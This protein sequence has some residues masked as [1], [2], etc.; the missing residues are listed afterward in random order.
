MTDW[1]VKMKRK[2]DK[3]QKIMEAALKVFAEKGFYLAS[4]D[5]IAEKSQISK[6]GLYFYFPSKRDLFV[7]LINEYGERLIKRVEKRSK[8]SKS[9][10]EKIE[11]IFDEVIDAFT[12]YAA[13]ARFLL[14][15][16]CTSNPV[17]IS[18]RE[19]IL[20]SLENLITENLKKAKENGEA[21]YNLEPEIVSTLILGSVYHLIVTA[22]ARKNLDL[23]SENRE[24]LKSFL[25]KNIFK[26]V[27]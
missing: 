19:K 12:K 26:E 20:E 10:K 8:E 25:L 21:E 15:E 5:E 22:L 24:K 7:S 13:L 23:I 1:S 16:A 17:F 4:I 14:I 18:E 9:Y 11:I 3:R 2:S 27:S 6:G